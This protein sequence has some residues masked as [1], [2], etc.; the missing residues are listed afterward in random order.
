MQD[1]AG[2]F[3]P[4]MKGGAKPISEKENFK[5]SSLWCCDQIFVQ[6]VCAK[7]LSPQ[8]CWFDERFRR[9][10]EGGIPGPRKSSRTTG[11]WGGASTRSKKLPIPVGPN[12]SVPWVRPCR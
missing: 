1:G 10:G 11:I 6:K 12:P 5:V 8:S 9:N 4:T 7:A 3:G 2:P